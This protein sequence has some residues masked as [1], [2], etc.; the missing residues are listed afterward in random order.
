MDNFNEDISDWDVSKVK[1]MSKMFE[2]CIYFDQPL[3]KW[4]NK[5]HNVED[6]SFM[7]FTAT[8]FDQNISNW[9]VSNV[10]N[11]KYMFAFAEVFDQ[12]L[13]NWNLNPDVDV[14][15]MFFDSGM[16]D[17]HLPKELE[18]RK[19][20]DDYLITDP[21]IENHSI[22]HAQYISENYKEYKK[23]NFKLT[24]CDAVYLYQEIFDNYINGILRNDPR[25]TA[26]KNPELLHF[27]NVIIN[28]FDDYFLNHA[29]RITKEM[30][31]SG[32]NVIYRGEKK[33]CDDGSCRVG[34]LTSF[35]SST[36]DEI[37][38]LAFS[39]KM[40]C[41]LYKYTLSEGIPYIDVDE[42]MQN[43][44]RK[45][46]VKLNPIYEE[47]EYILPRGIILSNDLVEISKSGNEKKI[48]T[49][50]K[51]ITYDENYIKNHPI[52]LTNI[53]PDL[54]NDGFSLFNENEM[55]LL[56]EPP[57]PP[58]KKHKHSHSRSHSRSHSHSHSHSKT[59]KLTA[60]PPLPPK[61]K[62]KMMKENENK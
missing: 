11:M 3:K 8:Y 9:D 25:F 21:V 58:S 24:I 5:L 52:D 41:C 1:N 49:Y 28:T 40:N 20:S 53:I 32:K 4:G 46:G 47:A 50:Q 15:Q 13:S 14:D 35:T 43:T 39:N 36:T 48:S 57:S 61:K 33:L 29:P 42:I 45:C 30:V 38:A 37:V 2:N 22:K 60:T 23:K 17:K 51:S 18:N 34:K 16:I 12:D 55:N 54:P 31:E 59:Q 27:F 6:M 7:F 26:I 19:N 62:F 44:D 10:K 56:P